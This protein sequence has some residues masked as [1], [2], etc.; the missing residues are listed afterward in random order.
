L[1]KIN[2]ASGNP[3]IVARLEKILIEQH[4]PSP[5]FPFP[6]LDRPSGTSGGGSNTFPNN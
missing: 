4:A 1:E 6:I 2:V 3:G 5:E